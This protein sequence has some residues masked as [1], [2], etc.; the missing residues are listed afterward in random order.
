MKLGAQASILISFWK[1][2][3]FNI[4]RQQARQFIIVYTENHGFQ[5]D[6]KC[7]LSA[8]SIAELFLLYLYM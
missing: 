8:A 5:Y 2:C 1:G 6:S 4:T 3:I 7:C